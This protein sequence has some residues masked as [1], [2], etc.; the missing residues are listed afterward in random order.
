MWFVAAYKA[1]VDAYRAAYERLAPGGH[2]RGISAGWCAPNP[3]GHCAIALS[4][5]PPTQIPATYL[6]IKASL[7]LHS[8]TID[9]R[10]PG[11][12]GSRY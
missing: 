12:N 1:F 4:P 9:P 3:S 2:F 11:R 5:A 6:A 10:L 7:R 8:S